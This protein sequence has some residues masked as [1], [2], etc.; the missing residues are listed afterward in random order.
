[1]AASPRTEYRRP[2]PATA[3][4]RRYPVCR[5]P[6]RTAARVAEQQQSAA[7]PRQYNL[8][9]I[10]VVSVLVLPFPGLDFALDHDLGALLDVLL[11]YLDE[12]F[13]PDN[14]AVPLGTLFLLASVSVLPAFRRGEAEIRDGLVAFE[15]FQLRVRAD[16]TDQR[17]AIK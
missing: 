1:M 5:L 3:R 7:E 8:R 9:R 4:V 14:N 11:D 16:V 2:Y 10:S 15:V 17:R 13:V 6:I 12:V